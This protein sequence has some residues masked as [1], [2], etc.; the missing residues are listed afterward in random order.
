[1]RRV[2]VLLISRT[3]GEAACYLARLRK[4][5][6]KLGDGQVRVKVVV[7]VT[8]EFVGDDEDSTSSVEPD[9]IE[10]VTEEAPEKIRDEDEEVDP[11]A[12][13]LGDRCLCGCD[14][15]GYGCVCGAADAA[16]ESQRVS[17]D[18][19]STSDHKADPSLPPRSMTSNSTTSVDVEKANAQA[20]APSKYLEIPTT[21]KT[22]IANV[23]PSSTK[24]AAH[25]NIS[26]LTV[27]RPSIPT[28]I[29][30]SVEA[31][32]G[33]TLVVCCGGRELAGSV[34][35]TVAG[36]SDERAVHKGTGAQGIGLW[37]EEFG[38]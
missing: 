25:G 6:A 32:W 3:A 2:S 19:Q 13:D 35:N 21:T 10:E 30:A 7:C 22:P 28:T 24:S 12:I 1:V 33:E 17:E 15:E 34:R 20:Q 16:G 9:A 23:R 27:A 18:I 29:R 14:S 4:M 37:V 11:R 36:L 8:R 26:L 38:I 5:A 31:A